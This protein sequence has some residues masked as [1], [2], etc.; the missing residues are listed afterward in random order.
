[1]RTGQ[2]WR[3]K[4]FYAGTKKS[5][6]LRTSCGRSVCKCIKGNRAGVHSG[7][8]HSRC[9]WVSHSHASKNCAAK[10]VVIMWSTNVCKRWSNPFHRECG[11]TVLSSVVYGTA[12]ANTPKFRRRGGIGGGYALLSKAGTID[13]GSAL[14][15]ATPIAWHCNILIPFLP[16]HLSRFSQLP[17]QSAV[18]MFYYFVSCVIL[19]AQFIFIQD[20][21]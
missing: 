20:S 7:H 14:T 3:S 12:Y 21:V 19:I 11:W 10:S 13:A 8:P 5:G 6:Q 17:N 16:E 15:R 1:M 2:F 9:R 4:V 18:P